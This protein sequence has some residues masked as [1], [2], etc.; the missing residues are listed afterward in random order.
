MENLEYL[1]KSIW[2]ACKSFILNIQFLYIRSLSSD[3]KTC[4]TFL[5]HGSTY[6]VNQSLT[7]FNALYTFFMEIFTQSFYTPLFKK[8]LMA[9]Q[10]QVWEIF[11]LYFLTLLSFVLCAKC[12]KPF[13]H[14]PCN[15]FSLLVYLV[16][17]AHVKLFSVIQSSKVVLKWG[18][19]EESRV[20]IWAVLWMTLL[21]RRPKNKIQMYL[22]KGLTIICWKYV[23]L[24]QYLCVIDLEAAWMLNFINE[25]VC[26]V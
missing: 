16:V 17:A 7:C 14:K 1:K 22:C 23:S 10:D 26:L 13:V 15:I 24:L 3:N 6:L 4:T 11:Y 8:D 18:R 25:C 2:N 5:V 20:S 19:R 12:C 9:D 21:R